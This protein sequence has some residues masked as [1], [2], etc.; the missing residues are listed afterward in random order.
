MQDP[1][2]IHRENAAELFIV[3]HGDAIPGAD[4]IIPSGV[5]D[6]LP[7]SRLGREQAQWLADRLQALAFSAIYSS[8]LLRCRQTAAPLAERLGLTPVIVENL[9]EIRLGNIRPWPENKTDLAALT[10][11][12]Q[13]R[14]A[15]IVR[16]AGETGHWDAI[17]GSEPSK[18][19]RRRVVEAC[20]AIAGRHIGQ[21]VLIFAHGGVVN[22]YVA[23]VLGL[24]RD[25]FFP[26][27]NTSITVV[28]AAGKQRVLFILNDIGHIKKFV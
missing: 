19:F 1:F 22:A 21:R 17:P 27:A 4:E 10:E 9:K 13:E 6:D 12:L 23:E 7:L 5:Y 24:E 15:D 18:E 11:A 20:D 28:R 14:Q 26:A 3:R 2:L 25:F 8:P 16:L